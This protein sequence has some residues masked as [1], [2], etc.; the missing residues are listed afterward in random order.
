[1]PND[2]ARSVVVIR[3]TYVD[4]ASGL[5]RNALSKNNAEATHNSVTTQFY[6]RP[7]IHLRKLKIKEV[8]RKD[9]SN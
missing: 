5:E 9:N 3:G 2:C 7:E 6:I 8:K 1:M 4:V